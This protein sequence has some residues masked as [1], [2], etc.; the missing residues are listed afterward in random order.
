MEDK[1][2]YYACL[3][4]AVAVKD[5]RQ[6]IEDRGENEE[7]MLDATNVAKGICDLVTALREYVDAGYISWEAVES[8]MLVRKAE[9]IKEEEEKEN[10]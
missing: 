4:L 2:L 7:N 5:Y 8:E 6:Q 9:E 3:G 1:N 10:N